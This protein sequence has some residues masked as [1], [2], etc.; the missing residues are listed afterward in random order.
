MVQASIPGTL[1]DPKSAVGD[2][3]V[4][5]GELLGH[6]A[7][8]AIGEPV[9]RICLIP[10]F[11]PRKKYTRIGAKTGYRRKFW[12]ARSGW[13]TSATGPCASPRCALPFV[14]APRQTH[15]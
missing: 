15:R 13:V 8:L 2:D 9:A 6:G 4:I 7:K 14:T 10:P 1:A 5:F 12:T 3:A 11:I